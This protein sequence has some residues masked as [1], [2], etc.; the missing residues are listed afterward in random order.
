MNKLDII[1]NAMLKCGLPLSPSLADC[2]PNALLVYDACVEEALTAHHWSFARAW[3]TLGETANPA[4]TGKRYAYIL[5]DDYLALVSVSP[6][7]DSRM[8][9]AMEVERAG[10]L[11]YCNISPCN[12]AYTARVTD[13]GLWPASF[14]EVVSALIATKIAAL[15]AEKMSMVPQL[16]QFYQLQLSL[17][18]AADSRE[19]RTRI[20][21]T[22]PFLETRDSSRG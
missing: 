22:S 12:L 1:N 6:F 21:Q 3:K 2:D 16:L 7:A 15:S 18:Q 20:P 5:P 13:P 14:A 19:S 11:L 4:P 10:R 8:P 9:Q 17:A